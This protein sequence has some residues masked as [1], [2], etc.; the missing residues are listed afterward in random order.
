MAGCSVTSSNLA[1]LA[2]RSSNQTPSV[3]D[4]SAAFKASNPHI[5]FFDSDTHGYNVIEVT[6]TQLTCAMKAVNTIKVNGALL[7][8][9]RVFRLPLGMVAIAQISV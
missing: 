5:E 8:T 9:M 6:P 4:L 7:N 3:T 1:E 2:A